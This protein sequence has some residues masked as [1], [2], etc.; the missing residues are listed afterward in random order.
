M[1][2]IGKHKDSFSLILP[3]HLVTASAGSIMHAHRSHSQ[4]QQK[5]ARHLRPPSARRG[6]RRR[7]TVGAQRGAEGGRGGASDVQCGDRG[8]RKGV[9]ALAPQRS[10]LFYFGE[11]LFVRKG[12]HWNA[13]ALAAQWVAEGRWYDYG[14]NWCAASDG[15]AG[16]AHYMQV[17]CHNCSTPAQHLA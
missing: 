16:C 9:R 10:P 7:A 4:W 11:N 5:H 15:A 13:M 12:R 14:R 3:H 8:V 17:V 6:H 2:T 1:Y